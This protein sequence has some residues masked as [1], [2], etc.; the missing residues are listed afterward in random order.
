MSASTSP[1]QLTDEQ[2]EA[3]AAYD[4]SVSLSAGAGCGKTFVLT[5]RFL[6]YLDPRTLQPSAELQELVAITFTDAAARE[7][8]QRI[9]GRCYQLY[10]QS[11][12]QSERTAWQQ[13][14]RALDGARISTIHSFC[15]TLLRNH[16]VEAEVD[17]QFEVLDPP[18]AELLRLQT[19]DDCLRQLLQ[20][21]DEQTLRLATRFGL[22]PLREHMA[23]L[24][25]TH[26]QPFLE[27]WRK[28]SVDQ[29]VQTWSEY[30]QDQVIPAALKS[31]TT[32]PS[33]KVLRQMCQSP[34]LDTA[35]FL[36]RTE[37]ITQKLAE[38][39][40]RDQGAALRLRE[41]AGVK[42]VCTKKQWANEEEY[43]QFKE[44]C[45][46][47]RKAIDKSP[48]GK[49]LSGPAC[50]EAAAVGLDLLQIVDSIA[51]S[52]AS[53]KNSQNV[54][55]FDDL[56]SRAYRLLTD[57]QY[58]ELRNQ[59]TRSMQLLMVDEFQ[60]T[61]PL[62][63]DIVQALCGKD[64]QQQG[65][66]VVGDHK[67]SIY[68]FRGAEPRVSGKLRSSLDS[69]GQLS[70]TTNFRSQPA[71]LEFVNALF[72]GA[73][74][75]DY[76]PLRASRQQ[77]SPTP[78]VEFLW[79]LADEQLEDEPKIPQLG[80]AQQARVREAN[81]IARR[82]A[83]LIDSQESLIPLNS[84][85]EESAELRPIE[86][87]DVAILMRSLSDVAI[88]E[89][90]LR[91]HGLDYY[92]AG[93]H[94][95]YAQQ[96]IYDVLNLLRAVVSEADEL[97][98]AGA[99]RSPIFALQDE[100]LFWLVRE[101][102]CLNQA[103]QTAR[104]PKQLSDDESAKVSIASKVL[105]ELR[106]Q[107]D[108]LLVAE[109]LKRALEL[110]GYDATVLCEFLGER[111][112]ANIHKLVEQARAIDRTRPGDLNGFITQLAELVV[113]APKEPL[114]TTAGVGNVIQI[115]TIHNAKGLEFPLVVLPDLER[116][117]RGPTS[118]PVF[119]L[120]LGPLVP[121]QEK[122]SLVGYD[123][124]QAVERE[125]DNQE[126]KRLLYVACTRAADYL[127][128]S[129]SVE[130]PKKPKSDW[131][132]LLAQNF[133]LQNGSALHSD[134]RSSS[135]P[136]VR[137]TTETP[138]L[139]RK[140]PR[141]TRGVNLE[142]M[143]AEAKQLA[144]AGKGDFPESVAAIPPNLASRRRFSFSRLT[145]ELHAELEV[146][147]AEPEEQPAASL[148]PLSF[149]TLVHAV[150]ERVDL[151]TP[152]NADE[153]CEFLAPQFFQQDWQ[154]AAAEAADLVRGFLTSDRCAQIAEARVVHNEVEFL[155]PWPDA[156]G[157]ESGSYLHGFIDC[158]YQDTAGQWH[159]LD[160]KTNQ[161]SPEG[162]PQLAEKYAMQM[163]V[164]SLACQSALGVAPVENVLYFLRPQTEFVS[165]LDSNQTVEMGRLI[166]RTIEKM[167]TA[168]N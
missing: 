94:A 136:L 110:T 12:V 37:Q 128:L 8:R 69:A 46:A 43:E 78:S 153:L 11:P 24:I 108:H 51:K 145:G 26:L 56:L 138:A 80:R 7:M 162:V 76:R 115:M 34:G 41:L 143:I 114:A 83:E 38:I 61:D 79:S 93:G 102:G 125:E 104:L 144:S 63:V 21:G 3:L 71:I 139:Q 98:L 152:K 166:T 72:E 160:Y 158:L 15:G 2:H 148:D 107:K 147:S 118:A 119:D 87:G 126:R 154:E 95:F 133:D 155:L 57:P 53:V 75:E 156:D 130:D 142:K 121:S 168:P 47:V 4:R 103:L 62:Q 59:L 50:Q 33:V 105:D 159:L 42:G 22:R 66:F 123:L 35:K 5:E 140:L 89:N 49:S 129:S 25:G 131:M 135:K 111:K 10:Q 70:L 17:P 74:V 23:S 100:T 28:A 85:S 124:H 113:R 16:A 9:R 151:R 18:A 163:F 149:G 58:Q 31:L 6:S 32:S 40:A 96:E 127:M 65:L 64:W 13:L 141:S 84:D 52:Y 20:E 92:L 48:L 117:T 36:E 97:S 55:E 30:H 86:L 101:S 67:Q 14:L 164:Y 27:R 109:L 165:Q 120:Q 132:K 112:L 82:L 116:S 44:A 29:L 134:E 81:L 161:V 60:D 157:P 1:R 45:T 54:L 150:L 146:K 91:Q 73:F 99:L 122:N 68:R 137:V 39:E 90:A 77:E 19:L 88:Y 106:S 167:R